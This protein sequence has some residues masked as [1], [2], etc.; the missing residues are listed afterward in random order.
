MTPKQMAGMLKQMPTPRDA[1]GADPKQKAQI[2]FSGKQLQGRGF[3]A[4]APYKHPTLG[5]VEVGGFAAFGD[6][7][8]P[9]AMIK[10]L[11]DGQV[12]WVLKLAE[13]LP[14]LK[15][16]K[17]EAVARG[18]GVYTVS[19]WVENAGYLPFPTA[20]GRPNRHVGPAMLLFGGKDGAKGVTFLSGRA[21]TPITEVDGGR[22][23]KLE[24]VVQV[25]PAVAGVEVTL[26]SPT[27]WGDGG[28]IAFGAAQGGVK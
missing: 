28:R 22:S 3:V 4:W 24:W 11:V 16:L 25:A 27:A 18:A 12:P 5:E 23:V 2:A 13:K 19:V 26:E 20:M 17:T 6:T 9:A 1:T 21:R 15:I 7:T 10:P 14:R 8:P